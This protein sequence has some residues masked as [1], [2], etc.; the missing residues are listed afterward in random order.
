VLKI[1]SPLGAGVWDFVFHAIPSEGLQKLDSLAGSSGGG[2]SNFTGKSSASDEHN[3]AVFA[4]I[5]QVIEGAQKVIPSFIAIEPSKQRLDFRRRILA[6]TPHAVIEIGR[7]LTK[8]EK[9]RVRKLLDSSDKSSVV[10][11]RPEVLDNLGGEHT[12]IGAKSLGE[13]NLM[14]YVK[15]VRIQLS[16]TSVWLFGEEL[17]NLD[18]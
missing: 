14:D 16:Q 11:A 2:S 1:K 5:T 10:E 7:S 9:G 18:I 3:Q 17:A 15:A 4:G 12:P 6:S 8:G 13:V